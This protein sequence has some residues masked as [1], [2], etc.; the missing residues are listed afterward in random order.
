MY[1]DLS[2]H[3]WYAFSFMTNCAPAKPRDSEC[4][5]HKNQ[6]QG[7]PLFF[8]IIQSHFGNF[9]I[10]RVNITIN[11]YSFLRFLIPQIIMIPVYMPSSIL[12][13]SQD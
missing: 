11:L 1:P 6:E 4:C 8:T 5:S 10:A 12:T 9:A 7:R 2:A 3:G 13:I